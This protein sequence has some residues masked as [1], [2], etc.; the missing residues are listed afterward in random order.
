MTLIDQ[1]QDFVCNLLKD[2]LS[3][4]Y[5]YHNFNHTLGVV[6]AVKTLVRQ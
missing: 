6:D 2:K 1:A 4:L 3:V 5:T